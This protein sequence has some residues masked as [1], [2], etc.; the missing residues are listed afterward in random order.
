MKVSIAVLNTATIFNAVTGL[1]HDN[2]SSA[3]Q[4]FFRHHEIPD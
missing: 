3:Q 2:G 1:M 4:G